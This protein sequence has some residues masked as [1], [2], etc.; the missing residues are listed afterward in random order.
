MPAMEHCNIRSFD[1][2]GSIAFYEDIVGLTA[3]PHPGVPGRGAWLYDDNDVPVIHLMNM[4][5]RDG[6]DPAAPVKGSGAIDHVAFACEDYEAVED[7]IA[8]RGLA[9]RVNEIES[10]KLRQIFVEDPSG[11]LIELNFRG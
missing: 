5:G 7:R 8:A 2:A 9:C 4:A 1:L 11:V 3:G 6:V 10:M